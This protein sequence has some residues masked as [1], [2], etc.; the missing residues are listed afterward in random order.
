[1]STF[2]KIDQK[3]KYSLKRDKRYFRINCS[4]QFFSDSS[5]YVIYLYSYDHRER[6]YSVTLG[7]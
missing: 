3:K 2:K 4:I 7:I 6:K 1:M 5:H